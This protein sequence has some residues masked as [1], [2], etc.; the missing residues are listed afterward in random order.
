MGHPQTV[1]TRLKLSVSRMG[2]KNPMWKGDLA[3]AETCR[4]RARRLLGNP[5]ADVHHI[6]GNPHNNILAN[7][8]PITRRDHMLLDGR[9][10][11]FCSS[12]TR[13]KQLEAI[14]HKNH[15]FGLEWMVYATYQ[16]KQGKKLREIAEDIGCSVAL[17]SRWLTASGKQVWK[18]G[19]NN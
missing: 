16:Y 8:T 12:E 6:D 2:S 9:M 11:K 18:R 14:K 10:Q 17:V 15:K 13:A 7:L 1:E 5:K 19:F 3:R 4:E